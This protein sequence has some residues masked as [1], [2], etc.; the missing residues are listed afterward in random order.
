[1]R[2]KG[3]AWYYLLFIDYHINYMW[4]YLMHEH[5]N[6]TIS[7]TFLL[8]WYAS[9]LAKLIKYFHSDFGGEYLSN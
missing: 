3:G 4:V 8:Q 9:T 5:T 1:M 6:F 7:I 2:S